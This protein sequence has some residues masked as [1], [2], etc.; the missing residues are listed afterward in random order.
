MNK[1]Y[2]CRIAFCS[3]SLEQSIDFSVRSMCVCRLLHVHYHIEY[4]SVNAIVFR[5][6]YDL[7]WSQ[8]HNLH[9][10]CFTYAFIRTST[11]HC[12]EVEQL[13]SPRRKSER[14]TAHCSRVKYEDYSQCQLNCQ[15]DLRPRG[16]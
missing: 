7:N 1:R 6:T 12:I 11:I 2:R 5:L 10:K 14:T 15:L 13:D 4:D 3:N 9:M 16:K 8:A